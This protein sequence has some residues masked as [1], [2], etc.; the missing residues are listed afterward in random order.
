MGFY[1]PYNKIGKYDITGFD[2]WQDAALDYFGFEG[3]YDPNIKTPDYIE[4]NGTWGDSNSGQ[5]WGATDKNGN[6]SYGDFAFSSYDNLKATYIGKENFHAFRRNNSIPIETQD[7]PGKRVYPEERLGF[8][9]QYKNR[10]LYPKTTIDS[11]SQISFYQ[12]GCY[13]LS[14]TDYYFKKWWHFIYKIPRL[15]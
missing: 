6:I 5:Y 13:N 7:V 10:G 1:V 9:N 14:S 15:W 8:I 11:L 12:N 2:T 4:Q 3:K